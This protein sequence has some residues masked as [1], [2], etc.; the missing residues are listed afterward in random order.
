[1]TKTKT[2]TPTRRPI[3]YEKLVKMLTSGRTY[4]EI[5]VALDRYDGKSADP[6]K[7]IRAIISR[8]KTV[9]YTNQKGEFGKLKIGKKI[10]KQKAG[11]PKKNEAKAKLNAKVEGEK[12]SGVDPAAK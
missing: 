7:P 9:G 3:P 6:T 5:A 8:M 11:R 1:M 2:K 12:E 4:K 10:D